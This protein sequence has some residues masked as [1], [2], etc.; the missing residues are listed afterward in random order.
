V[1][2]HDHRLVVEHVVD[3]RRLGRSPLR[4]RGQEQK[5][6]LREAPRRLKPGRLRGR[7]RRRVV[8][9][10]SLSEGTDIAG[11]ENAG[12][13]IGASRGGAERGPS[14]IT[15]SASSLGSGG[16]G[17]GVKIAKS[18]SLTGP[19]AAGTAGAQAA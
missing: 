12:T 1:R 3:E 13:G 14:S 2:A 15:R 18:G 19:V 5:E 17:G 9:R 16:G 10:A 4:R 6:R 11:T 7:S 8:G